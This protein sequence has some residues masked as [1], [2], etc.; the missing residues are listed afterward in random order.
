MY[1]A[2]LSE[3][4]LRRQ[5]EDSIFLPR[6]NREQ[7]VIV[8]DGMGGHNAGE[9]ASRLTCGEIADYI[10]TTS[11]GNNAQR[12][13]D[14][15]QSANDRVFSTARQDRSF[16]GMGSTVVCALLYEDSYIAA[17]VGDSRIYLV[18]DGTITQISKDHSFVA[19]LIE[20]GRL[21]KQ[22]AKHSPY[23]NMI[24]RSI[25]ANSHEKVDIFTGS[26]GE[27]DMLLLC[28]DGLHGSVSDELM[29][30][31]LTSFDSIDEAARELVK[32]AL[33]NGSTDNISLII[34]KNSG[35]SA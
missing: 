7:L 9:T 35:E 24:T 13:Y 20:S 26:W 15:V 10:Y 2:A 19:E 18:A 30:S 22:D 5:N 34:A 25:G 14:A 16:L 8:A 31:I 12:L 11:V 32:R 27:G 29:L 23:R 3:K 17:N 28:S 6:E 33:A 21:S 4:G 1:Y